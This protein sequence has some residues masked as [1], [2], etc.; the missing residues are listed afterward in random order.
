MQNN[1]KLDTS[2]TA[3]LKRF[4]LANIGS[5]DSRTALDQ[6][7]AALDDTTLRQLGAAVYVVE[8]NDNDTPR[9]VLLEALLLRHERRAP[10]EASVSTLP[11]YPND[12]VRQSHTPTLSSYHC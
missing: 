4:A 8:P 2:T 1:A 10:P 12:E 7:F 9:A 6:V 11:L 5:V 3:A